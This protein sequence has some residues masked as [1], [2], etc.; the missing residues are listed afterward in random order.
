MEKA[1]TFDD[2][3]LVPRY[4]EIESRSNVDTLSRL[5]TNYTINIPLIASPMST[6]CEVDMIVALARE[7]AVGCLHRFIDLDSQ[8]L[9]L[10]KISEHLKALWNTSGWTVPRIVAVGATGNYQDRVETLVALGAEIILIDVAHGD[11]IHVKR[12]ME[13][14][15]KLSYRNLFDVI[16]GNVAGSDGAK[17]LQDWG[18]DAIRV[19]IGGGS[20]CETRIRTGVG[21]PQLTSVQDVARAVSVPVISDGG[22]RFPGDVAKALAAGADTVMIGSLFAGTSEAPGELFVTGQ[23]P[24]EKRFKIYQGSASATEKGTMLNVE[25]TA[26]MIPFKG[27]VSNVVQ[28]IMDGVRSAMSYLGVDKI[29]DMSEVAEFVQ[30]TNAGLAEAHPHGAK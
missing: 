24:Q 29:Q 2:V 15:N 10:T 26:T 28:T 3:Q 25:G 1:L 4:S 27:P 13:W 14:I 17:R 21:V 6:V 20:V 30:I 11:H 8:G 22:I 9:M 7:E 16:V 5:T 18:A 19:G 12:A 23:W